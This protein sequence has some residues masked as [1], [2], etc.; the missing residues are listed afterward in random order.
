[1][2]V[3]LPPGLTPERRYH[4]F[5]AFLRQRFGVK[6]YRVTVDAG[7][8][9]PNVDGAVAIGGCVYCD[10]RSFSPNRRLPRTSIAA[11]VQR[12]IAVLQK[13]YGAERFL[14]YFQAATN[15]YAPAERLR[16]LYD[17]ALAHPQ[18][19]GLAVGTRPDCVPD[20]ILDLLEGYARDRYVCLEL[21][22][23]SIHDRSLDWMNRGHHFDS[24]VDAVRRC[25]GRGLDLCAHV[26][27]GLPGESWDDM[28][29]TANVLAALP[30]DGVKI[31]NLHVIRGT[32][33]ERMHEAGTVRMLE[34][35]E[36]V[37]LACD[38]LERLPAAMVIHRLSGDAPPEYLISP[39]WCL[40]KPALLDALRAEMVRRDAWQGRLCDPDRGRRILAARVPPACA[41]L[42]L[43]RGD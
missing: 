25:Q 3:A 39:Q 23:Q 31:H 4:A 15:T 21:G 6:V 8:T 13:R 40:D 20:E 14:A 16:R 36:Y 26:I 18:V 34:R 22:L 30:V 12:G 7:F 2:S 29:A 19:I 41:P 9:C 28:L 38:F 37:Q 17:E 24:F 32:P 33:L 43:L 5:S 27:L 10:N 1:M 11:Q 35:A 42:P